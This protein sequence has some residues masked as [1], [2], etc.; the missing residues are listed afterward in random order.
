M[1]KF[2]KILKKDK[3][4]KARAGVINTL[5]GPLETPVLMTVGTKANVK[6]ITPAQLKEIGVGVVLCNTYHLFLSPG[7][8]I[9][10]KMGGLHGFMN[11]DGPIFTDSGGFQIFSMGHG[12]DANEV[13]SIKSQ[14]VSKTLLKITEEGATFKSYID[15][16]KHMLTPE[17]SI[18]VQNKLGADMIVA[19]DECT[20][21]HVDK[22]YTRRSMEM[23]HRWLLRC[24]KEHKKLKSKQ[25]LYGVIQGGVYKDL[26]KISTDFIV[27][28]DT[29]G[30]CIGGSLGKDKAGIYKTVS[31]VIGD[32]FPED[33]PVHFLGIGSDL[34]ELVR[35]VELGVDTFDCVTP[36]RNARHGSLYST[37]AKNFK[38]NINNSKFRKDP[39]P[40]DKNCD[41]YVC[42]NFSRAY[43]NFLLR[44]KEMLGVELCSYHNIYFMN[45][46]M[47]KMR[48][49]ILDGRFFE[50]QKRYGF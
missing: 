18:Q 32:D 20:P 8:D 34:E 35:C 23:T 16:S 37:E 44:A 40:I 9:V 4:T 50:F 31:D 46:F 38:M 2:F 39:A 30:I 22:T 21:M 45:D 11:W 15:G 1:K 12:I 14:N 6:A 49:A 27:K 43:I 19:L 7:E 5:H 47:R 36:T 13:K 42:K 28:T 41:C 24:I 26:R 17:K 25:A 48:E 3:K 29:E 33:K 10:E